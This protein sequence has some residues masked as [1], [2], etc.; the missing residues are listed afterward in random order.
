MEKPKLKKKIGLSERNRVNVY[1]CSPVCIITL[2]KTA[3]EFMVYS[4]L[5]LNAL[6]TKGHAYTLITEEN[7]GQSM[8]KLKRWKYWP[9]LWS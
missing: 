4:M 2:Y 9:K 3:P 8:L 1:G 5:I 7:M 6:Q